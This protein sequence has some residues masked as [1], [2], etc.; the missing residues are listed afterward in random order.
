MPGH[1]AI[2][3]TDASVAFFPGNVSCAF[4][5][6]KC[7]ILGG[8]KETTPLK[9]ISLSMVSATLCCSILFSA[10]ELFCQNAAFDSFQHVLEVAV[11]SIFSFD[12]S[13]GHQITLSEV[14][15]IDCEAHSIVVGFVFVEIHSAQSICMGHLLSWCVFELIVEA[16]KSYC[17]SCHSS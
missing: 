2:V 8:M 12:S 9:V 3:L 4:A 15:V 11:C 13:L 5:K 10:S 7:R 14:D 17:P 16:H 1:R 6:T